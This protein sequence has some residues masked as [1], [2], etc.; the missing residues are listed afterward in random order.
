MT[1]LDK[2]TANKLFREVSYNV[3]SELLK[4]QGQE[5]E[6]SQQYIKLEE[7]YKRIND[8]D[9]ALNFSPDGSKN[10]NALFDLLSGDPKTI[11]RMI[12]EAEKADKD[13]EAPHINVENLFKNAPPSMLAQASRVIEAYNA[14]GEGII[15]GFADLWNRLV[16]CIRNMKKRPEGI[17]KE[18]FNEAK[19]FVEKLEKENPSSRLKDADAKM[20]HGK[21]QGQG[22]EVG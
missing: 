8:I 15:Q 16:N 14:R 17:T 5:R 6:E 18:K 7:A 12:A 1:Y 13:P 20:V 9:N 3:L 11:A 2:D 4:T 21:G 22:H 19:A 10:Q